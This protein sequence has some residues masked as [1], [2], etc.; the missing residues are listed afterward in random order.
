MPRFH[1]NSRA[2]TRTFFLLVILAG[3]F[4]WRYATANWQPDPA[5]LAL[6]AFGEETDWIELIA[7]LL[8]QAIQIFQGLTAG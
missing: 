6:P 2:L 4:G 7:S 3:I 5:S 8:E 1:R